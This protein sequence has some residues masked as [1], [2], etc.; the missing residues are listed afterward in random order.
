MGGRAYR[1][2]RCACAAAKPPSMPIGSQCI[3]ECVVLGV[4]RQ[5][6]DGC[7]WRGAKGCHGLHQQLQIRVRTLT[8]LHVQQGLAVTGLDLLDMAGTAQIMTNCPAG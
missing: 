2:N 5:R 8:R 3:H 6:V 7:A 1:A 4:V